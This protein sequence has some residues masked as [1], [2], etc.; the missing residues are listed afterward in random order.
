MARRF[1]LKA[2]TLP[3]QPS[4]QIDY[5]GELNP[6]QYAAAT[7][8]GGPV[9][10][11]AGAGTGKTRTLI[12]RVAYLVE[13][14]VRPE[15]IVLLTFTRRS[16][17]EMLTRASALLDGRCSRV[18]GGT[19]HAFC[20][21]LLRQHAARIGFE[22]TFSV[23]DAADAADVLDVLRT[24][25]GFHKADKR[26]PRKKTLYAM[27]SAC[28]N[29]TEALAD[30]LDARYPQ[31]AGYLDDLRAI[32][33][34]Y[35]DY[36]QRH[37]LMDYDDLL[38][39]TLGLFQEHPDVRQRVA[40]VCR[41]VLVDE[42]QDTNHPQADLVAAFASVHQNVMAVGDDAQSI[43][44]FRGADVRNIFAFPER[45]PGARVLRLEENYRSTQPI[46]DLANHVIQKAQRRY[47]KALFSDRKAGEKPG[48]VAAP[49]DRFESRFVSQLVLQLREEGV[50]L[51][52]MA[53]LFR[54]A[55]N[56]YDLEVEL[57]RRG[58][59]FVKYGGLK[60]NEA[61][62]IK[63][64]LAYLKVAENPKD[65]VAWNRILQLLPGVGPKTSR[66]LIEWTTGETSDPFTLQDRPYAPRYIGALKAL[67]EML[68]APPPEGGDAGA[69][70][71]DG[72]P[73]LRA[74]SG[75]EIF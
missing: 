27:L 8:P 25:G 62:H 31:F 49:D 29:R 39:R 47:D 58:I 71:G 28:A 26:F 21:S 67:F 24:A 72:D 64:V 14:G 48:L 1:V 37:G 55:F 30:V 9:L 54:S 59:P 11:V 53:V 63:D 41:H 12:Y 74:H 20:L 22:R 5:A 6:Q 4:L 66:Q 13:T 38:G 33:T 36:K 61:A 60:L 40:A 56:S 34:G 16:A 46:L 42:Y 52:R 15:E 75:T 35:A 2:D 50:P 68:R 3:A 32:Q 17:R 57:N 65:A 73:V 44:A 10:V 51:R 18:R 43:Y 69:A 45:F 7:A 70:G 19:F 23:L